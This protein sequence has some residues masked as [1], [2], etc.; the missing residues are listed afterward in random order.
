MPAGVD[1]DG[2]GAVACVVFS[3]FVRALYVLVEVALFGGDRKEEERGEQ[4][5]RVQVDER[6]TF[7]FFLSF[8]AHARPIEL[9]TSRDLKTS[10][11]LLE[12]EKRRGFL[13]WKIPRVRRR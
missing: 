12:R 13:S 5:K 11:F 4:E 8:F 9:K 3:C 6:A 1:D 10:F 7:F 2:R